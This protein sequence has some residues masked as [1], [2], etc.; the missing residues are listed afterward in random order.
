[1][2]YSSPLA[3]SGRVESALESSW[4]YADEAAILLD[5]FQ[6]HLGH[7]IDLLSGTLAG[8]NG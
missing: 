2:A 6:E 8:D 3:R 7:T 5:V 4:E 1:M